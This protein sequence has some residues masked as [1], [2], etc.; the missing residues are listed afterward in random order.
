MTQVAEPITD[1]SSADLERVHHWIGGRAVAGT[2]GRQGPVY[3]P[4]TGELAREVDFASI[5]EVDAAV[6]AAKAAFPAWRA[7]SLSRRTEIMFRVRNLAD[8][9]RRDIAAHPTAAHGQVPSDSLAEAGRGRV[10]TVIRAEAIAVRDG[11]VL[12]VGSNQEIRKLA[13][14]QTPVIDLHGRFAMPGFNDAHTHLASGGF[15]KLR[16]NL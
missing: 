7:P 6:A 13:G 10:E 16:V 11:R 9:H 15:T 4:A 3:N 2:S 12:D 1:R 5:E 8:A 14:A